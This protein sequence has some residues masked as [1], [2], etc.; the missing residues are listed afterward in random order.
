MGHDTVRALWSL[1]IEASARAVLA[2]ALIGLVLRFSR[3][4]TPGV[5]HAVWASTA[6]AMLAM[7]LLPRA[8]PAVP[9]AAVPSIQLWPATFSAS[10][11]DSDRIA[12]SKTDVAARAAA[13]PPSQA[14]AA[15]RSP[16]GS[17][18]TIEWP[19]LAG[20]VYVAGVCVSLL[21]LTAGWLAMRRLVSR[22]RP[23]AVPGGALAFESAAV[24]APLT[25]G[26][27]RPRIVLPARWR[28]WPQ[29]TVDAV[30][31]HERE[32]IRRRD[33]LVALL[34][35]VNR[36]V[37]WFHPLAW[38]LDAHVA[39]AAEEACDERA[40]AQSAR[41]ADYA[42]VLVQMADAV[43]RQGARLAWQGIAI[44]GTGRLSARIDRILAPARRPMSRA[45][46]IGVCA[47]CALSLAIAAACRVAARDLQP[48]PAV[49]AKLADQQ[50]RADFLNAAGVMT[51]AQVTALE[52]HVAA[53][54]EDMKAR[55]QLL[56]FYG[57]PRRVLDAAGIAAH[58]AQVLWMIAHHPDSELAGS[59]GMRLWT[60]HHDPNPDPDGYAQA[61]QLWFGQ[62]AKAGAPTQVFVNAARFFE[63][64]DKPL[65][66]QNWLA[67]NAREPGKWSGELGSLYANTIMGSNASRPLNVLRSV[68]AA[69]MHSP[70]ALQVRAKLEASRDPRLLLRA[71]EDL[72]FAQKASMTDPNADVIDFD[73]KALGIRYL[74]RSIALNPSETWAIGYLNRL[75][76]GEV[77]DAVW[78]KIK[79]VAWHDLPSVVAA[80]PVSEHL[81]LLPTLIEWANS[82]GENADFDRGDKATARAEWDIMT[83]YAEDALR[84]APQHP[85]HPRAGLAMFNAHMYLG[86][87][88]LRRGDVKGALAHLD[89]AP[90]V[91]PSSRLK[92]DQGMAGARLAHY[93]LKAGQRDAVATYEE[94]MA[95]VNLAE[96][97]VLRASAAA[98]RAG[99]M[100]EW[101]QFLELRDQQMSGRRAAHAAPHA[102]R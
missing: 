13:A 62:T 4:Q 6:A 78:P 1:L 17:V 97:P 55:E 50:A 49:T 85:E 91:P 66:E 53:Q 83:R 67:A 58:R 73:V 71:G 26:I 56:V 7:P 81:D 2:A 16:R 22:S 93:L 33:P 37:F 5:R 11:N 61:K 45:R 95:V 74:Q 69:D 64:A 46:T 70:Y 18:E 12:P 29:T 20:M 43:R 84:I 14:S 63:V 40:V 99:R 30:L 3:V 92:Y 27:V 35:R 75:H 72:V 88:A 44:S 57:N 76:D 54:P 42:R 90:G 89:A 102:P 23:A 15:V 24:A 8:V 9:V 80:M 38:W 77:W 79:G 25:A 21:W 41:P 68:S 101:Y 100:P 96:R 52:A 59:W 47:A 10:A 32:H 28:E 87:D 51:P 36:A 48:D 39:A 65:A 98:I 86:L 82:R 60:T 34:T 31:A 94:R 19:V